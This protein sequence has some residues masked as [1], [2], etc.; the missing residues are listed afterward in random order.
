MA[1][2]SRV[3]GHEEGICK[4]EGRGQTQD[5]GDQEEYLLE[6]EWVETDENH[7]QYGFYKHRVCQCRESDSPLAVG[8]LSESRNS[9]APTPTARP[10]SE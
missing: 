7:R 5:G 6:R 8:F 9:T 10:A 1:L 2:V 4:A 3:P